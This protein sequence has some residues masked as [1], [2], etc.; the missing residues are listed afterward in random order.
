MAKR[1]ILPEPGEPDVLQLIHD[2]PP[3][4]GPGQV[5]VRILAAGVARAD[6]MM[7]RGEYPGAV[8][9]YPYTPGYDMAGIV[10]ALGDG[11]DRLTVGTTVL[12]VIKTGGYDY[13]NRRAF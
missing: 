1:I 5:R 8:P 3:E 12:G 13:R 11:V 2:D 4:P 9:D 7:R 10:D 6:T